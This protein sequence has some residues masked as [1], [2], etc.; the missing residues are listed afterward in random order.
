MGLWPRHAKCLDDDVEVLVLQAAF[1]WRR[2]TLHA[3]RLSPF[4]LQDIIVHEQNS[5]ESD[6]VPSRRTKPWQAAF[7]RKLLDEASLAFETNGFCHQWS[8][9]VLA[10]TTG[11]QRA[12]NGTL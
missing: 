10:K 1:R 9:K 12:S 4:E 6:G 7:L 2:I 3:M 11:L 8:I 5:V